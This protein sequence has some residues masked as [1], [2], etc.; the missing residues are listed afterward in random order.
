M[1]LSAQHYDSDG[2]NQRGEKVVSKHGFVLNHIYSMLEIYTP[3][4]NQN[5]SENN[6]NKTKLE[7]LVGIF[8]T[9]V[10]ENVQSLYPR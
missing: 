1:I 10:L 5:R 6:K 7:D 4:T 8:Q 9:R 3:N 2:H